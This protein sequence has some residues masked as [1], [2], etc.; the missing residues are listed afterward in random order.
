M[1]ANMISSNRKQKQRKQQTKSASTDDDAERSR[2]GHR[3]RSTAEKTHDASARIII[4]KY[5]EMQIWS[6]RTGAN[7]ADPEIE[8]VV[9]FRRHCMRTF[10]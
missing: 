4:T 3:R 1:Q 8:I 2:R 6:C 7:E 10:R 9:V 5:K